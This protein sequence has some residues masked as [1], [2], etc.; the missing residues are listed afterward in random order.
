MFPE[1][2][3]VA[4]HIKD[5][6]FVPR[7]DLA[8]LDD[9]EQRVFSSLRTGPAKS[10]HDVAA[11]TGMTARSASHYV[12]KLLEMGFVERMGSG[13]NVQWRTKESSP[14]PPA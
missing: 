9:S 6:Y 2:E 10:I 7:V 4:N 11:E 3:Q 14:I 8:K 5:S 13:R 12:S 1:I